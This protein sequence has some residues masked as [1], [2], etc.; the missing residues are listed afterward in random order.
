MKKPDKEDYKPN[1]I[2]DG[3]DEAEWYKS[4]YE[5]LERFIDHLQGKEKVKK[6]KLLSKMDSMKEFAKQR[7]TEEGSKT[8]CSVLNN[9]KIHIDTIL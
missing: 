8:T 2:Y 4:Y 3:A 9:V 5:A 6:E 1:E 7:F